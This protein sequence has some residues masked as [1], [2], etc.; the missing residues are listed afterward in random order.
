MGMS[1][2][3]FK[4]WRDRL[5]FAK[6]VWK[7]KGLLGTQHSGGGHRGTDS[8]SNMRLMLDFYRG[9]Q[10]GR[11]DFNEL[12]IHSN[13]VNSANKVFPIANGIE[14]DLTA[15]SPRVK[16]RPR[17]RD[18]VRMAPGVESLYNYDIL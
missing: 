3:E 15:R 2:E 17:T 6:E 1:P 14:G 4:G 5:G 13:F 12:G 18:S 10:W 8:P 16:L 7:R 11:F 9:W